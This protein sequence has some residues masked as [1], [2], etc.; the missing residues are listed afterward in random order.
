MISQYNLPPDKLYGVKGMMYLV[1]KRLTMRGFIVSDPDFGPKYVK[2]LHEKV[3]QWIADG[4]FKAQMSIT[5]GMDHAIDGFLG[6]LKGENFGKAVL[7][8]ADVDEKVCSAL[9]A[10]NARANAHS[11]AAQKARI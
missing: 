5:D 4:T 2:E 11:E 6:M 8:I 1:T 10:L 9:L 3:G 7:K